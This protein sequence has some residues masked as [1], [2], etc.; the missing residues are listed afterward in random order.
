MK[1]MDDIESENKEFLREV[2]ACEILPAPSPTLSAAT[3]REKLAKDH[4]G[5][6]ISLSGVLRS[7]SS[8]AKKE[9]LSHIT[10]MGEEY[11][12]GNTT[13]VDEFLQLYCVA[14]DKRAALKDSLIGPEGT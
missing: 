3:N 7:N 4:T 11:Y 8:F 12:K 6:R 2:N 1:S 9:L 10:L 13:I 5:M 14:T